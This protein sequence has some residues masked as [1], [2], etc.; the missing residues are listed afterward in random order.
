[1]AS[2][3]AGPRSAAPEITALRLALTYEGLRESHPVGK[4]YVEAWLAA[5][6]LPGAD[7]SSTAWCGAFAAEIAR[8]CG[9]P[10]PRSVM[11]LRARAWLDVG[12]EIPLDDARPGWDIVVFQRGAPPQPP[13]QVRTAPG[14]VAW[15]L[16]RPDADHVEVVGGNQGDTVNR[17]R[18]LASRVLGVRRLR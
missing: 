11:A 2:V 13:A 8:R 12:E 15:F 5:C 18:F 16:S 6:G 14:H 7:A 4:L 10:M 17:A 3:G 9:L 1:V